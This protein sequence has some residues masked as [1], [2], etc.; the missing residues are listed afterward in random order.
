MRCKRLG[1]QWLSAVPHPLGHGGPSCKNKVYTFVTCV[2][3]HNMMK[4][5]IYPRHV[6]YH[7]TSTLACLVFVLHV[8]ISM[9]IVFVLSSGISMQ[10]E[11]FFMTIFQ[12]LHPLWYLSS[13]GMYP[14]VHSVFHN[15]QELHS[16]QYL[17]SPEILMYCA[18]DVCTLLS[19]IYLTK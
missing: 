13:P 5:T 12:E 10:I 2:N 1:N 8:C 3:S 9:Q 17:S 18:Y 15:I 11:C 14:N 19:F 7:V 4:M 6:D 16:F